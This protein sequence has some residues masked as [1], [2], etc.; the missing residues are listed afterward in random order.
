MNLIATNVRFSP[1]DYQILRGLAFRQKQSIAR[2]IRDAI[3][4]YH[5]SKIATKKNRLGLF[6]LMVNSRIK[7]DTPTTE[8]V[9]E[10]RRV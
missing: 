9:N 8:L 1:D 4:Q 6:R 5:N 2:I 7:I 10:G 3:R